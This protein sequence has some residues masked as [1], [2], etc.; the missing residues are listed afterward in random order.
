VCVAAAA[1]RLQAQPDTKQPIQQQFAELQRRLGMT[2]ADLR[3]CR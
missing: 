1:C 2:Q 3:V